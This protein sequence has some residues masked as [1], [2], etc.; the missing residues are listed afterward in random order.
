VISWLKFKARLQEKS[1]K[2]PLHTAG[3]RERLQDHIKLRRGSAW[4]E[5]T[6]FHLQSPFQKLNSETAQPPGK[7]STGGLLLAAFKDGLKPRYLQRPE[8]E[9]K[10]LQ[11]K[12]AGLT[13]SHSSREFYSFET[14]PSKG[15]G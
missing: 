13:T 10:H 6:S 3:F 8:P 11:S 5:D 15:A 14:H 12:H 9:R 2:V 1:G 7:H 4:R